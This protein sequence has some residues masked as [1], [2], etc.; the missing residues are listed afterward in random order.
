[1]ISWS[2][3]SNWL[4]KSRRS[5]TPLKFRDFSKMDIFHIFGFMRKLTIGPN[6]LGGTRESLSRLDLSI[7]RVDIPP[8]HA[9]NRTFWVNGDFDDFEENSLI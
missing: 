7:P 9:G 2:Y 5:E 6:D 3:E 8:S 4:R 1:M